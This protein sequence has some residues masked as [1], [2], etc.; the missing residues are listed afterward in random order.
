[1]ALFDLDLATKLLNYILAKRVDT[2]H[3][4]EHALEVLYHVIKALDYLHIP[5]YLK[6]DIQLAA[7]LHDGDDPKYFPENVDYENARYVLKQL[8]GINNSNIESIVHMISIVSC[9]K[10]GDVK[11]EHEWM[12]YPRYADRLEAI[13]EIGIVRCYLYNLVVD[14]PLFTED[15]LRATTI[16]ELREV[17]SIERYNNYI[18]LKGKVGKSTLIDHFYD[19]LLHFTEFGDNQYFISESN[20]RMKIMQDFV[21]D[22]GK[23]GTIDIEYIL[24]LKEKYKL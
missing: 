21:L 16:E 6:R 2:S 5:D 3:G 8:E 18:Q 7:F 20:N 22:F 1:M 24:S 9:S 12:L 15:T 13:G 19:K 17:A 14:R 11:A 23:T 10:N 4:I